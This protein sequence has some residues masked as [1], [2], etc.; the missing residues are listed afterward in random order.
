VSIKNFYNNLLFKEKG[1]I[2]I[3]IFIAIYTFFWGIKIFIDY[4]LIYM[5][6][7]VFGFGILMLKIATSPEGLF[8][9]LFG[10][11]KIKNTKLSEKLNTLF[12]IFMIPCFI[13][14]IVEMYFS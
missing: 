9:S 6:L 7:G 13:L 2:L 10:N 14:F 12:W 5:L 8:I 4:G 1:V 3:L 11:T